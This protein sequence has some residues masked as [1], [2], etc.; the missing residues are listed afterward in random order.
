M[1]NTQVTLKKINYKT[2]REKGVLKDITIEND[3][4]T[5]CSIQ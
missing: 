4:M 5:S 1:N 3:E 2:K